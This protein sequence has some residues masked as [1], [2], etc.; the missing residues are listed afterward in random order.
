MGS[1]ADH[2]HHTVVVI[3]FVDLDAVHD[4]HAFLR[5]I[6]FCCSVDV[7]ALLERL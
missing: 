6:T 7:G 2:D 5:T 4:G 1:I 3:V